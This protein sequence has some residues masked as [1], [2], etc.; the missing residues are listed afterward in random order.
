METCVFDQ[1]VDQSDTIEFEFSERIG[2][3]GEWET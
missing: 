3:D 1:V 2:G